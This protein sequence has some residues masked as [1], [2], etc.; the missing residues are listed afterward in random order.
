MVV[1]ERALEGYEDMRELSQLK[2]R[3]EGGVG[4]ID[5]ERSDRNERNGGKTQL[6]WSRRLSS[7]WVV[8]VKNSVEIEVAS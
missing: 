3:V 4:R 7:L 1:A 5:V 6:E 2:G 8:V